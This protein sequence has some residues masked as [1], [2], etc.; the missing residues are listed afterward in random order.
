MTTLYELKQSL[1]MI[2]EQLKDKN[3][4]LSQKASNPNVDMESVNQL[5]EEKAGLQQRYDIVES[6]VK[7]IEQKEQSKFKDKT[8]AYQSL[9]EENQIIKAKAEFYRHALNPKEY[10]KPSEQAQR[11]LHALPTDNDTGGD[12]FL[13]TTLSKELVSEPFARN[14]LREKARLTNIKGLEIPRISYTLDDDDFITDTETAKEMELK[15]DTVKFETYKF[16]VF[17]AVSDTVIHGSDVELVSWVENALRSGLADKE[18]RDAFAASPKPGIEHMSFYNGSVKEVAGSNM[19]KAIIN[20]LA[21]LHE[22]Y[23]DNSVIYMRYADY[24]K[25]IDILSNGTTNFFDAPAEK[26]FGKPIVFTDAAVKPVIGDFN[27]FG[28]N[29]NGTTFDTDKDVK[30]GEYLFV[31]TAWYDQQR[32]LDSAFRIAKVDGGSEDTNTP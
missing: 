14:Q 20:A 13:P 30:K 27:Y 6:Q 10:S 31:L 18:R 22:D 9:N 5:K 24:I 26:I 32:T 8:N 16:K 21:D 2:G 7:E 19:Y 1:G 3:N 15:G 28:I 4:E 29:Y 17:A 23:R 12:K 25:I 11:L